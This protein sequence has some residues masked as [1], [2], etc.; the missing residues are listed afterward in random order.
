MPTHD[1]VMI[2]RIVSVWRYPVKS[3]LGEEL[4]ASQVTERGLLGDRAYAFIDPTNGKIVSAKNP[5]KWSKMFECRAS[6]IAP[7]VS[8]EKLPNVRMTLQDGVSVSSDQP[9]VNRVVSSK[10][11]R[12]VELKSIAP[13]APS[14]EEYWPDIEGLANREIVTDEG[15][16]SGAPAGTF[17]DFS[18]IHFVTTA[19]LNR[20]HDSYPQGRF[21]LQRFRPNFVIEPASGEKGF[22]ENAWAG[23]TLLI[24]DQ[25]RLNVIIPCAR[26][27]MTTM[28]QG[29]LP[30]D[31]G[32]LRTI[33]QQNKPM[34]AALGAALPSVGA[35]ASVA[36]AGMARVGDIVRLE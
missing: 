17:F 16:A 3:M 12:E 22:P 2:G 31:P 18:A 5:S 24:G 27:V 13:Q 1:V 36:S 32:I 33:A 23:R 25:L 11:G 9:D 10:L 34:I 4:N 29:T 14:L 20:L 6:F 35:Y 8:G 15:I 28:A 21:E 7:P 30:K 19:T 26:C